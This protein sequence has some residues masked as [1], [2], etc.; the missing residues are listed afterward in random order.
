MCHQPCLYALAVKQVM[1]VCILRVVANLIP[2]HVR[3]Q[4]NGALLLEIRVIIVVVVFPNIITSSSVVRTR[5][6]RQYAV[7]WIRVI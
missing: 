2:V 3:L 7:L 5:F 4:T 6:A 1:A